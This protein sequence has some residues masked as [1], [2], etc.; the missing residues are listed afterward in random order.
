MSFNDFLALAKGRQSFLEFGK[1]TIPKLFID[2]I[3]EAGRWAPSTHNLQPWS[4]IVIKNT[5]TIAKLIR[6]CY[7]GN[8]HENPPPFDCNRFGSYSK[9]DNQA[10]A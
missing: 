2:K 3:L 5:E 7:Y 8:F 10:H 9:K 6:D 4:F 1:E